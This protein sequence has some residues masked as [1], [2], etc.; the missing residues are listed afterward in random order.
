MQKITFDSKKKKNIFMVITTI[1]SPSE[2]SISEFT[3]IFEDH[4]IIVVG[5]ESTPQEW[6][7]EPW[8]YLSLSKQNQLFDEISNA[9]PIKS[10]SR[11]NLGYLKAIKSNSNYIFETDDDNYPYN[12]LD[13]EI[14]SKLISFQSS[15]TET[16]DWINIYSFFTNQ[17]IWPRGFPLEK[18][19]K[20]HTKN[21]NKIF[22][23]VDQLGVVQ[24]LADGDSD[25]DAI[26]R[27]VSNEF[28]NFKR[29]TTITL[30]R[31]CYC[32]FNSQNT[33]W[34]SKAFPLMYI[35]SFVSFRMCDIWR[36]F[37]AIRCLHEINL[38]LVY[39]SPTL[40]QNRNYHD[41][42]K[43]FIDEIDGYKGNLDFVKVL[44]NLNIKSFKIEEMILECYEELAMNTSF[45]IDE[46]IDI[47][48][49]WLSYFNG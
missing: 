34:F 4:K 42:S 38:K 45:I 7:K 5:D 15:V 23:D 47:L 22:I 25:V 20:P 26:Y 16:I 3:D 24:F 2:T 32:P 6:E 27:L 41:L 9:I 18:I 10:Y 33:L 11:K 8:I 40:Y 1:N 29:E 30:N 31:N 44:K 19:L 35:P 13:K 17:K 28:V 46:E 14:S 48:K 12:N 49:L 36:S 37:I 43:D 39:S 21:I